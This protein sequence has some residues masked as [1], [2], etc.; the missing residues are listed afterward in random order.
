MTK[1]TIT[2]RV[3]QVKREALDAIAASLARDRTYVLNEAINVY[4]QMYSWQIEEIE[5]AVVEADE[6]DFA[7]NEEVET[8][9]DKLTDAAS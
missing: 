5:K 4:I 8:V 7:S 2:F 6:G 1:E 9:F 3:D